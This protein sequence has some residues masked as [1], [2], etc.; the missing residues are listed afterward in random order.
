MH[1]LSAFILTWVLLFSNAGWSQTACGELFGSQSVSDIYRRDE[2]GHPVVVPRIESLAGRAV[3]IMDAS[4]RVLET[5]SKTEPDLKVFNVSQVFAT[6]VA[7]LGFGLPNVYLATNSKEVGS[8]KFAAKSLKRG[9]SKVVATKGKFQSG[10]L[11]VFKNLSREAQERIYQAAKQHEGSRKWTCVNAN[12]RVLEDAGF[13]IGDKA[14]SKYYMPSAL[15]RDLLDK[16]L[17]YE[18]RTIEF[19]VVRTTPKFL[20]NVGMSIDKAVA[21]TPVRHA[22]RALNPLLK[23]LN[24][25]LFIVRVK[26]MTRDVF[27]LFIPGEDSDMP[28]ESVDVRLADS[29]DLKRYDVEVSEPSKFGTLL[30]LLWGPHSLFQTKISAGLVDSLLPEVL[31]SFP[32]EKPSI[33]TQIKKNFIFSRPVVSLIRSQLAASTKMFEGFSEKDLFDSLRTDSAEIPNRYN[34]VV[35]G[36]SITIMKVGIKIK[37]VD[38]VLSKHVLISGYG[39]DVR[40][41]GEIWKDEQGRLHINGN[42]GTYMPHPEQVQKAAE[43]LGILFPHIEIVVHDTI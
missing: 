8:S 12:C 18:G 9:D 27:N 30:R 16:G 11:I 10:L 20:E 4:G 19:D 35:T 23:K 15:L 7:F 14:P 41:A 28:L 36:D 17:Q 13:T 34:I 5:Q 43:L 31:Q 38:W 25:N 24:E 26:G 42:S 33:V 39:T 40:F 29:P 37:F 32:Q 22:E 21:A 2:N 6:D 3:K 1:F